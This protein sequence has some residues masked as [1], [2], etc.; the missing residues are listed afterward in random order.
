MDNNFIILLGVNKKNRSLESFDSYNVTETF[1]KNNVLEY[2]KVKMVLSDNIIGF[3]NVYEIEKD[4]NRYL[5]LNYNFEKNKKA[6]E[7][8][9]KVNHKS[10]NYKDVLIFFETLRSIDIE[11]TSVLPRKGILNLKKID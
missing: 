3:Y 1:N 6:Y 7:F 2:L 10:S 9:M 11:G 5:V 8:T 4:N